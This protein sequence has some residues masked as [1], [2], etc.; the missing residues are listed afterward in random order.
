[1]ELFNFKSREDYLKFIDSVLP[2]EYVQTRELRAGVSISYYP[3]AIQESVAD[4]AFRSWHVTDENYIVIANELACTVRITYCPDYPGAEEMMCTGSAASPIQMSSGSKVGDF[5]AAKISNALEYNL[6]SV[7]SKA[8]GCALETI[9][10]V[11]G[12]NLSR[13]LNA[14]QTLSPNFTFRKHGTTDTKSTEPIDINSGSTTE[15]TENRPM[16]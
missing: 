10:N 7:R 9:G 13:K 4:M 3:T 11:F 1:M 5:P 15:R 8:I 2:S 12:R 14:K 16:V 6:P